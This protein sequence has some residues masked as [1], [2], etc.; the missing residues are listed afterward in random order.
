MFMRD[1]LIELKRSPQRRQIEIF[2][3]LQGIYAGKDV[4]QVD[5]L[6]KPD[7]PG[8]RDL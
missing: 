4:N 7:V 3:K 5:L 8:N 2:V 6:A 1:G